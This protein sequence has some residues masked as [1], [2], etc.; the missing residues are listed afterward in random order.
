MTDN[1]KDA[2]DWCENEIKSNHVDTSVQFSA[3]GRLKLRTVEDTT[4]TK[5]TFAL[6]PFVTGIIVG[7]VVSITIF[8]ISKR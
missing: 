1:P 7:A 3:N 5:N 6:F 8:K 4:P 2:L